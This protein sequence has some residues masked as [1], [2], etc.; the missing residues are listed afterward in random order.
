MTKSARSKQ[1]SGHRK[2][3]L[4]DRIMVETLLDKS[5]QW[6]TG[7]GPDADLVLCTECRLARNL[8]D[9]P[10]PGQCTEEERAAI[11]E[12]V[13]SAMDGLN[14]FATGQYCSL[15]DLDPREAHFLAERRLISSDF[16]KAQGPR[17]VYISD[18]Q[19]MSISVNDECHLTV[20]GL[21]SGVQ[22]QEVW[23]RINLIDDT[24]A[25]VL[26]FAFNERLGY[27]TT[28]LGEVGTGL[29]ARLL[30]HLPALSMM[31]EIADVQNEIADVQK[32]LTSKRHVMQN[33]YHPKN[34][35]P[36][37]LYIVTNTA[38][39]GRSEEETLFHA[40]HLAGEIIAKERDARTR[41][42]SEAPM[43]LEDRVG[44]ALGLAQR[45]R[46]LAFDEALRVLSSLRLGV[47][48]ALLEQYSVSC[49]NE[50]FMAAQNG[51][52]EMKCGRDCDEL[53]L[54]TERASLF[55]SRLA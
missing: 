26:D 19:S 28:S 12:R 6:L 7:N 54:S 55:R 51:H 52:I 9:Y 5:A 18:D 13:V 45:A 24:L 17:G 16:A 42:L 36:G 46:L 23:A 48:N 14:L 10:Y 11:E 25:G 41:L 33:L 47:S 4:I 15:I 53:T 31:N 21:A 37:D 32:E 20:R 2:L 39:L 50:L 22:L 43:Q 44:R 35:T 29:K 34:D 49:L 38:T 30:L 27:L 8:A 3:E 40:K 1:V